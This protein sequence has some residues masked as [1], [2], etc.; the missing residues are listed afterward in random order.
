MICFTHNGL[1][2]FLDLKRSKLELVENIELIRALENS[3]KIK[4]ITLLSDLL[5]LSKRLKS[6]K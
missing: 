2:R 1:E 6:F 5:H 3:T 4:T